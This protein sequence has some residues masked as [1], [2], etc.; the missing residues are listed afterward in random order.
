MRSL[1]RNSYWEKRVGNEWVISNAAYMTISPQW[2][3]GLLCSAVWRYP[4]RSQTAGTLCG[5]D[6]RRPPSCWWTVSSP[7]RQTQPA[8]RGSSLGARSR[9]KSPPPWARCWGRSLLPSWRSSGCLTQRACPPR[10]PSWTQGSVWLLPHR[11]WRPVRSDWSR[12]KWSWLRSHSEWLSAVGVEI[13]HRYFNRV[14]FFIFVGVCFFIPSK[15]QHLCC[16]K[17]FLVFSKSSVR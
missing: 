9:W 3:P 8:P 2:P 5:R 10:S 14:H 6:V 16:F 11:C 12:R 15:F 13:I 4:A 17:Q 7:G 1:H